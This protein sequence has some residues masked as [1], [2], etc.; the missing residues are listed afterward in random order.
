MTCC[1][2]AFQ[3][4]V[5]T[6]CAS[7]HA[8]YLV[9]CAKRRAGVEMQTERGD[10]CVGT[11]APISG[12][13]FMEVFLTSLGEVR[14]R[15]NFLVVNHASESSRHPFTGFGSTTCTLLVPPNERKVSSAAVHHRYYAVIRS[16]RADCTFNA[17][18]IALGCFLSQAECVS[19][20]S[21][22]LLL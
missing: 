9:G 18:I 12:D 19:C 17:A 8:D 20:P 15:L 14:T 6:V 3:N 22:Y 7:P 4:L 16:V 5:S 1:Y 10:L 2:G 11:S 13:D 21:R